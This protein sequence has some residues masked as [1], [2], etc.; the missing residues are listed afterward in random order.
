[1]KKIR[2]ATEPAGGNDP[3]DPGT[4]SSVANA[5]DKAIAN[6]GTESKKE[7]GPVGS[8]AKPGDAMKPGK[9]GSI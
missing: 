1:M 4:D 3:H 7:C 9:V 8:P 6:Q 5:I 2:E